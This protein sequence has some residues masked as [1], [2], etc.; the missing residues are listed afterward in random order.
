MTDPG[1]TKLIVE[2]FT[3]FGGNSRRPGSSH[4]VLVLVLLLIMEIQNMSSDTSVA[5]SG[6]PKNF[7]GGGGTLTE[8]SKGTTTAYSQMIHKWAALWLDGS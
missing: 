4:R 5:K 2:P 7:A 3:N 1:V 8:M 6:P